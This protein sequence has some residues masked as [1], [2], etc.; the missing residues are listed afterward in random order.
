MAQI[1]A[2][3]TVQIMLTNYFL[4]PYSFPYWEYVHGFRGGGTHFI[5]D[6]E[7]LL[8]RTSSSPLK[9]TTGGLWS[10]SSP[11]LQTL[12][13]WSNPITNMWEF[14][15]VCDGIAP[16][17][18]GLLV[19]WRWASQ[20]PRGGLKKLYA[21]VKKFRISPELKLLIPTSIQYITLKL[22][23]CCLAK[24]LWTGK[25]KNCI[26]SVCLCFHASVLPCFDRYV[27]E[28]KRTDKWTGWR[29]QAHYLPVSLSYAVDKMPRND[30]QFIH[31]YSKRKFHRSHQK[32]SILATF[33]MLCL[34]ALLSLASSLSLYSCRSCVA[35]VFAHRMITF[36]PTSIVVK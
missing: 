12:C 29:Y 11:S 26:L 4:V 22:V 34:F 20:T 32:R 2:A 27:G 21:C 24:V 15:Y 10:S 17:T 16:L 18:Q 31:C 35:S 33:R 9:A 8:L 28:R 5:R 13:Q 7:T 19:W 6:W 3:Q 14:P 25:T 30:I 23:S 36:Y 1:L